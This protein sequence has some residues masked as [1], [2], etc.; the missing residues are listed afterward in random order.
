MVGDRT[1]AVNIPD[2]RLSNL[3]RSLQRPVEL[4]LR[5]N[6]REFQGAPI[7]LRARHSTSSNG[8]S[9]P[10][11]ISISPRDTWIGSVDFDV[12]IEVHEQFGRSY[13]YTLDLA[14]IELV[15]TD[16]MSRQTRS[17]RVG[18]VFDAYRAN[19][20]VRR[21]FRRR[22]RLR[23]LAHQVVTSNDQAER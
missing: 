5:F 18:E 9:S 8:P 23:E 12:P 11:V 19:I 13:Q 1:T 20:P 22:N 14:S 10:F 4:G 16:L 17:V 7:V 6:E 21:Q 2:I 15:V 3:S